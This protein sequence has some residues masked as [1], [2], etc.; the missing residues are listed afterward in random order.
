[1][2][3]SLNASRLVI[4][5]DTPQS[6]AMEM[7]NFCLEFEGVDADDLVPYITEFQRRRRH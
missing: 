2:Q 5:T 1:M 7:A 6:I 3:E 4:M